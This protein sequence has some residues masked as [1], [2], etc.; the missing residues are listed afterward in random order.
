[1]KSCVGMMACA[2]CGKEIGVV[3]DRRLRETFEHTKRYATG[4]ICDDCQA[5]V[6]AQQA[7]V[8]AGGVYFKCLACDIGGVIQAKSEG[9]RELCDDVRRAQFGEA[10]PDWRT[11]SVGLEF[12]KCQEHQALFGQ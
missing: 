4:D 8:A 7:A 2:R 11:K 5:E 12:T 1:M 3:L 10:D 9:A 6:E